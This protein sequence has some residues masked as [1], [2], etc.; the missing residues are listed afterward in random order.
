MRSVT[1]QPPKTLSSSLALLYKLGA[2]FESNKVLLCRNNSMIDPVLGFNKDKAFTEKLLKDLHFQCA[3]QM[4]NS[5]T[6]IEWRSQGIRF[7]E[8]DVKTTFTLWG[9][10]M[11]RLAGVVAEKYDIKV[12]KK[13][14]RFTI[15]R[16]VNV[17]SLARDV[18]NSDALATLRGDLRDSLNGFGEDRCFEVNNVLMEFDGYI[19]SLHTLA[20][21]SGFDDVD[22]ILKKVI[23]DPEYLNK[24]YPKDLLAIPS[25]CIRQYKKSMGDLSL[26]PFEVLVNPDYCS[27]H[28]SVVGQE[29]SPD[30]GSSLSLSFSIN[31]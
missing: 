6:V 10:E 23:K 31:S 5:E 19:E 24:G 29:Y 2:F 25:K 4:P 13:D 21:G 8:Y 3:Q 20:F 1:N 28:V 15:P 22:S 12:L 16:G 30:T 11:I 17:I 26:K 18:F 9:E 27:A 14:Q 7:Y